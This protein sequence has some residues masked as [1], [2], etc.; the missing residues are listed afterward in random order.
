MVL[1]RAL[2]PH[3]DEST[4][5][6]AVPVERPDSPWT[7]SYS[8]TRQ[9][10]SPLQSPAISEK[11]LP[12]PTTSGMTFDEFAELQLITTMHPVHS[13]EE[14]TP[15]S[16][17]LTEEPTAVPSNEAEEQPT[18]HLHEVVE[19]QSTIT[20]E[21]EVRFRQPSI[22]IEDT[23]ASVIEEVVAAVESTVPSTIEV[24]IASKY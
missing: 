12:P 1:T 14:M 19:Q 3:V 16:D 10:T 8:V 13:P 9:G 17:V 24:S 6:V 5:T 2:Q 11:Q 21:S 4:A 23:E 22:V 15:P 18:E 20:N 7:P